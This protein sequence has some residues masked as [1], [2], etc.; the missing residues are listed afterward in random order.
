MSVFSTFLLHPKLPYALRPAD[1]FLA[2]SIGAMLLLTPRRFQV[3][4]WSLAGMILLAGSGI[5]ST[6]WNGDPES[7]ITFFKTLWVWLWGLCL[8]TVARQPGGQRALALWHACGAAV[9]AGLL[10]LKGEGYA[11]GL[12]EAIIGE[13]YRPIGTYTNP[14][15]AASHL[16]NGAFLLPL[17]VSA[18]PVGLSALSAWLLCLWGLWRTQSLAGMGGIVVGM[19]GFVVLLPWLRKARI[20]KLLLPGVLVVAGITVWQFNMLRS[21]YSLAGGP[22][23]RIYRLP[24]KLEERRAKERH[25]LAIWASSPLVGIGRGRVYP[26]GE[27]RGMGPGGAHNEYLTTLAEAG[28]IGF[29]GLAILLAAPLVS[30]FRAIGRQGAERELLAVCVCAFL[31]QLFFGWTHDIIHFR[32]VWVLMAIL[33]AAVPSTHASPQERLKATHYR[34]T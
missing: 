9:G 13:S 28:I 27:R 4:G 12:A 25:S 26:E 20:A 1:A 34:S 21:P 10:V 16:L 19:V 29:V 5:V 22:S 14:N 7:V 8:Y 31:G 30:G 24:Y 2:L 32:H 3:P 23:L 33:L 6:L 18:R 11:L 17:F 15:L